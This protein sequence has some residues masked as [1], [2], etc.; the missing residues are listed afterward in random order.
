MLILVVSSF[1]LLFRNGKGLGVAGAGAGA[2][3]AG[4]AGSGAGA[5]GLPL[6]CSKRSRLVPR[7]FDHPSE[8]CL[9]AMLDSVLAWNNVRVR[10]VRNVRNVWNVEDMFGPRLFGTFGQH[11]STTDQ[12]QPKSP[13]ANMLKFGDVSFDLGFER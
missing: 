6:L 7:A 12:N 5:R 4:S 3:G 13:T 11:P 2:A 10:N 8:S 9:P 1:S